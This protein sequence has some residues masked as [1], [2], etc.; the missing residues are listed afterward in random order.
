MLL[1][2]SLQ[3]SEI[4]VQQ[5]MNKLTPVLIR[6]KSPIRRVYASCCDTPMFDIGGQ[7]AML[8]SD[9]V[10]DEKD[11]PDVT[12]RI[13]GRHALKNNDTPNKKPSISWSVPFSWF[14]TMPKRIQKDKMEPTPIDLTGDVVHVMKDFQEG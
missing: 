6:E 3:P 13:I 9:L 10:K 12:F 14:W 1:F 5:G 11:K 2:V 8:N 7:A 4:S